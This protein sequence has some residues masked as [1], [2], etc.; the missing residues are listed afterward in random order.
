[1]VSLWRKPRFWLVVQM[2]LLVAVG[3]AVGLFDVR[4]FSDSP[5]YLAAADMPLDQLLRYH[6]TVGYPFLLR[7]V[8]PLSPDYRIIPWVHLAVFFP[9]VF[10]LDHAVRRFGASPWLAFAISTG[11]F[12][13]TLQNQA[14]NYLGTDFLGVVMAAVAVSFLLWI[15]ASLGELSLD[16]RDATRRGDTV[17]RRSGIP[18]FDNPPATR[19]VPAMRQSSCDK[20][21]EPLPD[22]GR[23]WSS[24]PRTL[25][26]EPSAPNARLR[27]TLPWIGLTVS[28]ACAYHIRPAYLFLVGLVPCLG[29]VLLWIRT[30]R[31]GAEFSWKRLASALCAVSILPYLGYC[32]ARLVLVGH[33]GLVSFSGPGT[34]ALAVEL[35]DPRMVETELPQAWRPLAA[36]ILAVR[37]H[38]GEESVFRGGGVIKLRQ[39]ELRY[40]DN[41]H[42]VVMPVADRRYGQDRI[43]RNRELSEFS[44]KVISLRK[45]EY[46][47]FLAY[48][49]P[50]AMA[51]LVYCGWAVQ[52]FGAAAVLLM[53]VR[54]WK[55]RHPPPAGSA[56]DDSADRG[57]KLAAFWLAALFLLANTWVIILVV[58]S[59]SRHMLPAGVFVPSALAILIW[60][61]LGK[62]RTVLRL[63]EEEVPIGGWK[64]RGRQ[65]PRRLRASSLQRS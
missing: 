57:V 36:E 48:S 14:V 47:L 53:A 54:F 63:S 1:M 29:V 19:C 22:D 37:R 52:V 23:T 65:A 20:P 27:R 28:L 8:A 15:I 34:A 11:F 43:T 26:P 60:Q 3:S 44:L 64:R 56:P 58:P 12:W 21:P 35:I 9:A 6:R 39:W 18:A 55:F 32:L 46:L 40:C 45:A 5:T 49:F 24:E 61:E 2:L 51:K 31:V 17:R 10:L 38:R 13:A 50:R 33:F 42:E 7:A 16:S 25:N 59:I 4:I 41:I 30:A 62:I